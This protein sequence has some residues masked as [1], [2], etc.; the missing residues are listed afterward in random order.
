MTVSTIPVDAHRERMLQFLRDGRSYQFL[1]I[2]DPYLAQCPDDPYIR[3]MAVREYLA[4]NLIEPARSLLDVEPAVV[5]LPAELAELRESLQSLPGAA[6]PWSSFTAQFEA[7]LTALSDRG[8]DVTP[9][10]K[11]WSR[12]RPP[13]EIGRASCRER[14]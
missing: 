13:D 6:I 11:A 14:V 12:E 7:N 5:E 1:S 9:I 3:L 2:A 4:L 8:V 10:R